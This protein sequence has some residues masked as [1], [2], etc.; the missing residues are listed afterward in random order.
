MMISHVWGNKGKET[1]LMGT[2]IDKNKCFLFIRYVRAQV[3]LQRKE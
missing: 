3:E 2:G 1:I